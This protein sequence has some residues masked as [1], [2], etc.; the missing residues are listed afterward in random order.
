[1]V[2]IRPATPADLIKIQTTNLWCLP[3]NYQMKYYM[4][5]VL[6]W[7]QLLY[8]AED[9]KGKIQGYVLAKMEEDATPAHGHIT[10][11]AVSREHRKQGIATK[12]MTQ[13]QTMMQ[14]CFQ[15]EHVSL[16]VRKSNRA[17]FHLYTSTLGYQIHDI[18]KGY[19]ADG[20]DAYDMRNPFKKK[21]KK[22]KHQNSLIEDLV[23]GNDIGD[24]AENIEGVQRNESNGGNT[25]EE[26][27]E[28]VSEMMANVT[29]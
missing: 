10:S 24:F 2:S 27:I 23:L 7:P 21:T 9:H 20:E 1:M 29:T 18:E 6:S 26:N 12:M 19:Y 13:S 8:V 3:E 22:K 14:D 17:A 11:L 16:H 28:Q 15:G 25:D 5:H 4:Y